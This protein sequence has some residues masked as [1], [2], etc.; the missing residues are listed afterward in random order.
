GPRAR[1]ADRTRQPGGLRVRRPLRRRQI[2]LLLRNPLSGDFLVGALIV[3]G[4]VAWATFTLAVIVE[5]T[6]MLRGVRAPTLPALGAQQRLA[7]VLLAAIA[8]GMAGGTSAAIAS[9]APSEPASQ[10]ATLSHSPAPPSE[11]QVAEPDDTL[12]S[13]DPQQEQAGVV[14]EVQPGDTLWD[15][16]ATHLGDGHRWGEIAALNYGAPQP[17]GGALSDSHWIEP[18][19]MLQLPQTEQLTADDPAAQDQQVTVE[20]GDTLYDLAETHL[21]DG[22]RYPEIVEATADLVQP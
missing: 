13:T 21:G 20:R 17:D 2:Q 22:D 12:A 15:L 11:H 8:L 4:W 14:I 19:W 3:A 9:P 7:A 16:A 18:G 6:S 5:A 1:R 10:T